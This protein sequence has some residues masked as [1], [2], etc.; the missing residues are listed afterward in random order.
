MCIEK[1]P[2]F[3]RQL[4]EKEEKAKNAPQKSAEAVVNS[5]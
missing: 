4:L 5:I 1:C 2:T 3:Y